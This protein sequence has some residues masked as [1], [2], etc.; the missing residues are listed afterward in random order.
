MLLLLNHMETSGSIPTDHSILKFDTVV[1]VES[2]IERYSSSLCLNVWTV[3]DWTNDSGRVF[4]RFATLL[5]NEYFP[6]LVLNL[7]LTSF[8]L[9]PLVSYFL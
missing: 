1:V 4:H 3:G 7:L 9:F 2:N 6:W 8:L 5:E